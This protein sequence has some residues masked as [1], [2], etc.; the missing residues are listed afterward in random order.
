VDDVAFLLG[1]RYL[2][3]GNS[4]LTQWVGLLG[5]AGA[6]GERPVEKVLMLL[7]D[8]LHSARRTAAL[9]RTPPPGF[10]V[11]EVRPGAAAA[12]E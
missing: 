3:V 8:R 1:A 2:V 11:A 7:D 4:T 10:E 12:A 5:L 9:R 6:H